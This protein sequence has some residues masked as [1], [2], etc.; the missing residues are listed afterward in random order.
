MSWKGKCLLY[1]NKAFSPS[2]SALKTTIT[3]PYSS[4]SQLFHSSN[5]D[6]SN[7]WTTLEKN[8]A[9]ELERENLLYNRVAQGA[10]YL[11]GS[12]SLSAMPF[13]V[14]LL[15]LSV[16]K[17]VFP[18]TRSSSKVIKISQRGHDSRTRKLF[19]PGSM[20]PHLTS[21]VEHIRGP[22]SNGGP[23]ISGAF[24]FNCL[25]GDLT[26]VYEARGMSR[27]MPR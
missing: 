11:E 9:T 10:M 22:F 21:F 4:L 2:F 1:A 12:A 7:E 3:T 6:S 25:N 8:G 18:I 17:S 19:S 15:T 16:M 26:T 5:G 20:H 24:V 27:G 23:P 14:P 13:L